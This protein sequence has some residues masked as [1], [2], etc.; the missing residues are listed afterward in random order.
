MFEEQGRRAFAAA[1]PCAGHRV[2]RAGIRRRA[3]AG[4]LDPGTPDR[5]GK[6]AGPGDQG[7][8]PSQLVVDI[9]LELSRATGRHPGT[10][11]SDGQVTALSRSLVLDVLDSAAAS[12]YT[13][14][15]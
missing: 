15:E 13:P 7:R 9:R 8:R 14:T 4:H 1:A 12:R 2:R 11:G 6:A 3:V 5:V 10:P